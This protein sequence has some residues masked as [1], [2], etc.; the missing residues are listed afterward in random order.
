MSRDPYDPNGLG[1]RLATASVSF[2]IACI[3]LNWGI[4]LLGEVWVQLVIGLGIAC[5]A[6][7]GVFIYRWRRD[8]W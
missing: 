2:F 8:T 6:V 5:L 1:D 4:R 3:A 7:A